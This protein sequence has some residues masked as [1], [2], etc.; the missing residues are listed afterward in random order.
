MRSYRS[1]VLAIPLAMASAQGSAETITFGSLPPGPLPAQFTSARTGGGATG[2]WAVVM[3]A[4]A[5][6]DRALAQLSQDKTDYRFPLAIYMPVVLGD[7]EVAIRFRA[8]S[9]AVDRAAGI[10][11]RLRDADNY[12]VAR[13]NALEHNVRFYR[14]LNGRRE[15][16]RGA[17]VKVSSSNWHSLTLHAEG[18]RFQVSF[19]GKQLIDIR[20]GSISAPGR[21]ALWTK[22]DSVTHFDWLE[23]KPILPGAKP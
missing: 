20:D 5:E 4:S 1:L 6:G 3:D 13:A 22:A 14:V 9:G 7:V 10:A 23:I 15:E 21:V 18:N 19:D 11:V 16:L 12:Y 17:T 2:T 8:V